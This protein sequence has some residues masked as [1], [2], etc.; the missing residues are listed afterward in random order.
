MFTA[1]SGINSFFKSL[2]D[3]FISGLKVSRQGLW[4]P[5]QAINLSGGAFVDENDVIR[6][7]KQKVNNL[8]FSPD[9]KQDLYN[10]INYHRMVI[11]PAYVA[12][13]NYYKGR[14]VNILNRPKTPD[15]DPDNRLVV[16]MPKKLVDTFNG[17]FMGTP[18]KVSYD[19][20]DD[21][22]SDKSDK[23][24]QD[25]NDFSSQD[26]LDDTLTECSKQASIFG[27]SYLYF[28]TDNQ[29]PARAHVAAVTP[30]HSFVVYDPFS[31]EPLFAVIYSFTPDMNGNINLI[32]TLVTKNKNYPFNASDSAR[33]MTFAVDEDDDLSLDPNYAHPAYPVLPFVEVM[34][35]SERL[36]VFD[37]VLSLI[38][39]LDYA[40]SNKS[41]DSE[42]FE[43]S[44]LVM[45]GVEL[46]DD[47]RKQIKKTRLINLFK[48]P[49][50]LDI[51][52]KA[53]VPSAYYLERPTGDDI[54]EHQ[55]QHDTDLIYQISQIPD[56]DNVEFNTAAAQALDF[57]IHSMKTKALAKETKFKRALNA[58][59]TCFLQ[60][61][62]DNPDLVKDLNYTFTQTIPHNLLAEAQTATELQSTTSQETALSSLSN[63]NDPKKEMD[64]IANENQQKATQAQ[65]NLPTDPY[66]DVL[67]DTQNSDDPN[68]KPQNGGTQVS[69]NETTIQSE[70][71]D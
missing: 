56:L 11:S 13:K 26:T 48:N 53:Q 34:D 43:Q 7:P 54:Q 42:S 12:K 36:G 25:I 67:T 5:Q 9:G 31:E 6:Y 1:M 65:N 30:D 35:N 41:N 55:I 47:E 66:G 4:Q 63:V 51:T 71:D 27:R 49:N 68:A 15:G 44:I 3:N 19:D 32:G 28:Y 39:D 58:I 17:Y 14:H 23:I 69:N 60:F 10:M 21:L 24:N 57:K 29:T 37:D 16:N 52:D 61:K 20:P 64:K 46:S 70:D 38:D 33:D 50:N 45:A 2:Q 62:E 22:N 40:I 8:T 18:I 59:F